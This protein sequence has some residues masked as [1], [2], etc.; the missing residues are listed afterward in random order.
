MCIYIYLL[1][2]RGPSIFLVFFCFYNVREKNNKLC[3]LSTRDSR[4]ELTSP[5]R[6]VEPRSPSSATQPLPPPLPYCW[7]PWILE[8]GGPS[9]T[10]RGH[11]ISTRG[12][13]LGGPMRL[14]ALFLMSSGLTPSLEAASQIM[15]AMRRYPSV[16]GCTG[17]NPHNI[18]AA[19]L[20]STAGRH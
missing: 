6:P 19:P 3:I 4:L 1:K 7:P 2:A 8:A 20:S 10:H 17:S 14:P 13:F 15:S 12:L 5:H 16:R 11:A 18:I 9:S